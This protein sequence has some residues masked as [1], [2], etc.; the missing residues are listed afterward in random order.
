MRLALCFP[1]AVTVL[2]IF[3]CASSRGVIFRRALRFGSTTRVEHM[4]A[5]RWLA[6]LGSMTRLRDSLLSC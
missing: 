6:L 1:L 4:T 3:G 2:C 5:A